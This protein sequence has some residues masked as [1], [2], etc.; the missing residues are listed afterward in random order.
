MG[1][2]PGIGYNALAFSTILI[3]SLIIGVSHVVIYFLRRKYEKSDAKGEHKKRRRLERFRNGIGYL[4][5]FILLGM[6]YHF[7]QRDWVLASVIVLVLLFD[8]LNELVRINK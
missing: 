3:F 1:L 7:W 4:T 6:L 8:R 2:I 5:P